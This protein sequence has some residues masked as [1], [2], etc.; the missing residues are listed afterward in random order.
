MYSKGD[1][2]VTDP[3]CAS[4]DED[5]YCNE[6]DMAKAEVHV[7]AVMDSRGGYTKDLEPTAYLPHSCDEWVIGGLPE[8]EAMITDLMLA[9]RKISGKSC[10]PFQWIDPEDL[11]PGEDEEIIA[12]TST[13]EIMFGEF[14]EKGYWLMPPGVDEEF[15]YDNVVAWMPKPTY[16]RPEED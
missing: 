3:P 14:I 4:M 5:G 1:L 15:E 9:H 12:V 16:V 2:K 6:Y 11:E 7:H 10:H 8:I 13:G